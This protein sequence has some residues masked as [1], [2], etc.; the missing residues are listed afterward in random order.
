MSVSRSTLISVQKYVGDTPNLTVLPNGVDG[1]VF[2]RTPGTE[3]IANQI[4]FAGVVR[5]VKGGDVLV[6]AMRVLLDRGRNVRLVFA[7]EAFY[8]QYRLEQE[9]LQRMVTE[10]G[11]D[12]HV[13]FAGKKQPAEL[14]RIMAQSAVVV[15]PSRLESFGM[16]LVEALACGTPVVATRCGGPEDI[17]TQETGVLVPVEDPT[18]LAAGIEHVLENGAWYHPERLRSYALEHFNLKSVGSRLAAVYEGAIA[19]HA[20]RYAAPARGVVGGAVGA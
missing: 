13:T 20:G 9:R 15:L 1:S 16:V 4:L 11:L 6:R 10:L 18:A 12:P 7:G 5:P 19:R 14:A 3:R 8:G 17:V 2:Q